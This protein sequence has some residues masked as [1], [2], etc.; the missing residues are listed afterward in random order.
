MR[1]QE[2]LYQSARK[3]EKMRRPRRETLRYALRNPSCLAF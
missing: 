1:R 2:I 3:T